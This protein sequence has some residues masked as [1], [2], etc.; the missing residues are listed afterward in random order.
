M[1]NKLQN[2]SI[3]SKIS[4]M[5]LIF[6]LL[7][8]GVFVFRKKIITGENEFNQVIYID[9]GSELKAN[10][11]ENRV[12]LN[13]DD[14]ETSTANTL[15]SLN[16][17]TS[18]FTNPVTQLT[19]RQAEKH[20]SDIL[21]FPADL[22]KTK[23]TALLYEGND[24]EILLGA[25][26]ALRSNNTDILEESLRTRKDAL[27]TLSVSEIVYEEGKYELFSKFLPELSDDALISYDDLIGLQSKN[28]P[29][30]NS[31]IALGALG[32]NGD[33][34]YVISENIYTSSRFAQTYSSLLPS[35]QTDVHE[36]II[37]NLSRFPVQSL[38]DRY[39]SIFLDSSWPV[40][41]R[42]LI[43]EALL[44][45][46]SII[47]SSLLK[48]LQENNSPEDAFFLSYLENTEFSMSKQENTLNT[49]KTR[50]GALLDQHKKLNTQ[51][52]SNFLLS[53]SI[54]YL[55]TIRWDKRTPDD[56]LL[57]EIETLL[58][59]SNNPSAHEF[60]SMSEFYRWK[61]N[62]K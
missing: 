52:S 28:F 57:K 27:T 11:K 37:S 31:S 43:T 21:L 26:I 45:S 30:L 33:P 46:D 62:N 22:L 9:S 4:S 34:T 10:V 8:L 47:Q 51:H 13:S 7:L 32:Y 48:T 56:T 1:I 61:S 36:I 41:Q 12:K 54:E 40:H 50:L 16:Q 5:V 25:L 59:E 39:K 60:V 17:I 29:T 35:P 42:I 18:L 14:S 15:Q 2:I 49:V 44:Y 23:I 20:I 53:A 3:I 38:E 58:H 6:G 24:T 19:P 55:N